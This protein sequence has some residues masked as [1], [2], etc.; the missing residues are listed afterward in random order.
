MFLLGTVCLLLIDEV[1]MLHEVQLLG[2]SSYP[3]QG[4]IVYRRNRVAAQRCHTG[5]HCLSNENTD[6]SK[7]LQCDVNCTHY[8]HVFE[9]LF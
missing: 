8:I 2:N 5:D 3:A 9:V 7:S 1:H 4:S 6:A